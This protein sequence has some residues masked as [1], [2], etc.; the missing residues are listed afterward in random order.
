MFGVDL[1]TTGNEYILDEEL[2]EVLQS[3]K[4]DYTQFYRG[5]VVDNLDATRKGRVKVR[6]PQI[7]GIEGENTF[8]PTNALPWATCAIQPAGHD[9]GMF[10]PPN[11]GDTVFVT[12]EAGMQQFPI[13]FGGIYTV[14]SED[15]SENKGVASRKLY[16]ERI[17]PVTTDDLPLEVKEGTERVI[18]K[19]LKGAIIYIDDQDG[20]EKIQITDQSGQSIIMENLSKEEVKR[21][22]ETV[23]KNPKSQIVLTNSDG[24]SITLSHG[25]IHLKSSNI[26]FETD[27]LVQ[28][29]TSSDLTDEENLVN[30]IL[31]SEED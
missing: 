30:I 25:K 1:K 31:G 2:E 23:G 21:R 26:I 20:H 12:F 13:Y 7:H 11:I 18:Y 17:A 14:R 27:N 24:D 9:S 10:L 22:G 19:S 29:K 4:I 16:N 6:I 28:K 5:I 3:L 15:D 8:T